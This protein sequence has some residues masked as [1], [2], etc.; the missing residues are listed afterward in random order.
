MRWVVYRKG[1]MAILAWESV[2]FRLEQDQIPE[3]WVFIDSH[4]NLP[5]GDQHKCARTCQYRLALTFSTSCVAVRATRPRVESI[6]EHQS[7]CSLVIVRREDETYREFQLLHPYSGAC[8]VPGIRKSLIA[9]L[10]SRIQSCG[11]QR[12]YVSEGT[13]VRNR[14]SR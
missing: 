11:M 4:H 9:R 7:Y 2:R 1:S 13:P 3:F 6:Y 14:S 12:S 8:G 5:F 10:Y